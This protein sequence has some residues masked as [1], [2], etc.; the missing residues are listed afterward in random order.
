M[1]PEVIKNDNFDSSADVWSLGVLLYIFLSGYMPFSAKEESELFEKITNAKYG[2]A[3][4]EFRHVSDEAKD[5]IRKMLVIDPKQR[6]TALQ[7]LEHSWFSKFT[8]TQTPSDTVPH[9]DDEVFERLR[10]FKGETFFKRAAM[11]I[12]VKMLSKD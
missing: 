11:N 2:F 12:L 4:K 1:A 8:T 5:L 10:M 7:I 6:P 3:H 9:F